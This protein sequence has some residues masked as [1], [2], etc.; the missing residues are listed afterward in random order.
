[1]ILKICLAALVVFFFSFGMAVFVGR[2]IAQGESDVNG[3]PER[4]AGY[5]D[6]EI[7][8]QRAN[9]PAKF[10]PRPPLPRPAD[11]KPLHAER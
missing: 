11:A 10:Y 4:D 5:S 1:M 3:D 9:Q 8:K 6:E 2:W 7:D